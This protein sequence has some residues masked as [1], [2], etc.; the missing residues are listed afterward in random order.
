MNT[1][2][3]TL[4]NTARAGID[5]GVA[6]QA[7]SVEIP[8]AVAGVLGVPQEKLTT[9]KDANRAMMDGFTAPFKEVVKDSPEPSPE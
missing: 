3:D 6:F 7:A 2:F 5:V 9:L 1:I 4:K 8:L